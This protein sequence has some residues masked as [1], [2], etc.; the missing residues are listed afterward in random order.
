MDA[1]RINNTCECN[2]GFE[3]VDE[4]RR[5]GRNTSS[6]SFQRMFVYSF[7]PEELILGPDSNLIGCTAGG[8]A[9][10]NSSCSTVY[11]AAAQFC[12]SGECRCTPNLSFA[13]EN[14]SLCCKYL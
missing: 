4:D 11:G 2:P 1:G 8:S 13:N 3:Q 9:A 10:E 7:F 12:R 5:C 14:N 6:F